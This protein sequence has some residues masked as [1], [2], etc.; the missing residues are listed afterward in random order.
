MGDEVAAK[1]FSRRRSPALPREGQALPGRVR[2][3]ARRGAVR[4]RP[5]ARSAW[6]S[7]STSPTR[8]ATRRWPTQHVLEVIADADFQTELAQFNIEINIPPRTLAGDGVRRARGRRPREPQPRR[9]G[10]PQA[11]G[12]H[13][14]MVGILPTLA[15][16]TTSTAE[17]SAPTRA[18]R[19]STSRSSPPA[20][21]TSTSASTASSGCRPTPTR[22]RPRRRA[23]AC[24][25]TCRSTRRRSRAHWNAAQA[26][27]GIQ[28]AV[29]ANSPFFFGKRA[30]A[31]DAHRAV[32]AGDRH[33]LGGA[34]GPGRAPARVVRRALDHVDLRPVRGERPLLPGAAAGVRGR[35]PGRGRSSAATPRGCR[36]CGCTTARSTAGTARSTTSCAAA[37]TCASRT[38]CCRPGPTVVD[39]LA[40]AAFYYGLVRVLADEDRPL[41]TQMSFSA[42]EENF[43]AGARDG[44]DA[45][46]Y[47]PGRR[48]GAGGRAGAAA[49]AADGPRGAR[50]LGRRPRP[51]ATGCSGS[52]SA[53]A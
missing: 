10:R 12:A 38:A 43:H 16:A 15:R 32:R 36:S 11:L 28:L 6:R 31:R 34:E 14:M 41:W 35:G 47:W 44:I 19:C 27:A 18:T 5:R 52:S 17:C 45:R 21:R 29:G 2:A 3:H 39:I 26:I 46:V 30:V 33:A 25:C 48:R 49:A 50:P 37:R 7:S 42:A 4:R 40:N 9:G 8:P 24:S 51:T 1:V 13:M 53:A 23:R 22:S 20:G